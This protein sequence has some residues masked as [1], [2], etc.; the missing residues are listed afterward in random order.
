MPKDKK[1][2]SYVTAKPREDSR[3]EV[4][5]RQH[6]R[7]R[8]DDDYVRMGLPEERV[9]RMNKRDIGRARDAEELLYQ[10]REQARRSGLWRPEMERYRPEPAPIKP[11][12]EFGEPTLERIPQPPAIAPA[13]QAYVRAKPREYSP[14]EMDAIGRSNEIAMSGRISQSDHA[15]MDRIGSTLPRRIIGNMDRVSG[16]WARD[17]AD[18]RP[19][20]YPWAIHRVSRAG[21]PTRPDDDRLTPEESDQLQYLL[22]KA[23]GLK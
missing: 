14:S 9:D 18:V 23:K 7:E 22:N 11:T 21:E 13:R 12:L 17:R 20:E 6:L 8:P 3:E 1:R 4:E 16:V 2:L 15:E 10:I 19:G 5:M